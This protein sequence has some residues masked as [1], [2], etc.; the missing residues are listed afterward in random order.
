V[1]DD[2]ST[3]LVLPAENDRAKLRRSLP[4]GGPGTRL[5]QLHHRDTGAAYQIDLASERFNSTELGL[6]TKAV[7]APHP[8]QLLPLS[9]FRNRSDRVVPGNVSRL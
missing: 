1:Q 7:L 9:P 4:A 6:A 2:G 5:L 3:T 8:E